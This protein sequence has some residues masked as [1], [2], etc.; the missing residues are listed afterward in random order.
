[1]QLLTL[2]GSDASV[3]YLAPMFLNRHVERTCCTEL[4]LRT[5]QP[6]KIT[7]SPRGANAPI[8]RANGLLLKLSMHEQAQWNDQVR[9][10]FN[11]S[12]IDL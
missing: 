11:D 5:A 8:L 1:M 4:V 12:L 6:L 9:L 2:S 10:A 3:R 7:T